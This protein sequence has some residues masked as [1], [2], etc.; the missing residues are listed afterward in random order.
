VTA[1]RQQELRTPPRF[2]IKTFWRLHRAAYRLTGGRF[3]LK[4]PEAGERFGMMRLTTIGRRSGKARVAIIGYYEDGPNLVTLAMNGWADAEPAWWLNLQANPD[5]SVQLADG[6]RDVRARVSTGAERERLWT[7]FADYPGWGDDIEGLAGR[8]SGVTAI[9]VFE[10]RSDAPVAERPP[11]VNGGGMGASHEP[12]V[13]AKLQAKA[14]PGSRWRLRMRHG[15]VI[16]GLAI[17]V[18]ASGE[19]QHHALGLVPLLAFGIAPHL[20]V[21]AG[22]A[23]PDRR[24]GS[25]ATRLFNTMHHPLVP[26]AVLGMAATGFLSPFWFVG[27]L[28]WLSHIVIDWAL[29]D[30]IRTAEGPVR[31]RSIWSGRPFAG[32]SVAKSARASGVR[33]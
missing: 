27:A 25:R 2:V 26:L 21:L 17:A 29:G 33:A 22:W 23:Q 16:P 7:K 13:D 9:V 1:E 30:G 5:T 10:P 15:W 6:L 24:L 14:A 12:N 31:A 18:Y 4:S 19:A 8:R 11:T 28:A 20:T 3:G 32:R